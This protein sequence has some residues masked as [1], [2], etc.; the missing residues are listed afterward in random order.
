MELTERRQIQARFVVLFGELPVKKQAQMLD[1]SPRTIKRIQEEKHVPTPTLSSRMKELSDEATTYAKMSEGERVAALD[2]ERARREKHQRKIAPDFR[3]DTVRKNHPQ[4][5]RTAYARLLAGEYQTVIDILIDRV[6]DESEW[7]RIPEIVRPYV[8]ETL[9]F[10]YY[11]TG[12]PTEAI[13]VYRRTL[14]VTGDN[15]L[16][17]EMRR[18]CWSML[19][20]AYLSL[21]QFEAGFEA[22]CEGIELSREFNP[23][24]YQALCLAAGTR[25]PQ[26]LAQW[27]GR[28]LE[29]AETS[30]ALDDLSKFIKRCENDDADLDWAKQQPIWRELISGLKSALKTMETQSTSREE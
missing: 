8:L 25:D 4:F 20:G 27:I 21:R 14:C 10:A 2:R 13:D 7:D 15:P 29:A 28:T 26:W 3:T 1:V 18:T 9:G 16:F 17:L 12:R 24:Y 30:W 19:A 11:Y 23:L 22:V 5:M 6:E